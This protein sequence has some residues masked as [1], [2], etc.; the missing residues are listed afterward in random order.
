MDGL[1]LGG[2]VNVLYSDAR[3]TSGAVSLDGDA[4]DVG[5]TLGWLYEPLEGTQLGVAY[6][7]G[8]DLRIEGSNT[9]NV[10]PGSPTFDTGATATLPASVRT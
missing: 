4:I 2:S 6:H 8:H 1:S 5:F 3:L 7:H 10:L 9:V